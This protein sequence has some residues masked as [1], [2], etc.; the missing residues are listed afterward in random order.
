MKTNKEKMDAVGNVKLNYNYYVGEDFY[1][2]G[3]SEDI[4]LDLVQR[5]HASEYE[6]VIQNSRSWSVM[7]HL[8]YIRE[9]IVSWL[10]IDKKAKV[11]E[12]GAGCGA[13]TG[14]LAEMAGSVTCIELSKKRSLIN[15]NR[16]R[17]YDNIEIIVGNFEEIEKE[18]TEK[19]DYITLIGVLEYAESYIHAPDSYHELLCAV[20]RH[21]AP[22]GKLVTAIENR[23]GLKYFAGCK[24]DHTG[25]YYSGIEGYPDF[26]GVKT[27]SKERLRQIMQESGFRTKF[28]FPYPDY[29]LPHTIYSDEYLPKAGEL[30]TNLRNFDA[31]RVVTFDEGR[32]FDSLIEEGLFQHFSNSFLVIASYEDI[33]ETCSELPVFAK[34]ANERAAQYRVA[35]VITQKRDK[36][37]TV[38][39][40][41]LDTRTN[42]HIREI[43]S[44]YQTLCEIYSGTKLKP[45]ACRFL[46][47]LEPA[48]LI[49]GVSSKA[50]DGVEL[51]YLKGITLE[52][53][54]DLLE[55]QAKYEV[56][57]ALIKEYCAL[58][59]QVGGQGVFEMTQSFRDIF[60]DRK[61]EKTYAA[62]KTCNFDMIFSNIVYDETEKENGVWNVLDYEWMYRFPIPAQFII[63]R[64]LFY[65]FENRKEG[66][67][68]QYLARQGKDIYLECG[69]DQ[70]ERALFCDMEHCF[71]VYIISGIASL[72]VMQVMMPSA[73]VRLDKVLGIASYLRNLN[74]PKIYFSY[75]EG[76]A[77]ENQVCVLANV[78]DDSFVSMDISLAS[79]MVALRIDPTDY[80]CL[81]HVE[82]LELKMANG[83]TKEISRF[84]ING[85]KIDES[86]ILFDT[87]DA[88]IILGNLPRG[89][90]SLHAEYSVTMIFGVFYEAFRDM[91]LK[92]KESEKDKPTLL[93]RILFK[94]KIKEPGEQPAGFVYNRESEVKE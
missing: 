57:L 22:G 91:L 5:Y 49:A 34:Y 72:E 87:D 59:M 68:S 56:M 44:N 76:F 48:P 13:I 89:A 75:G 12:I 40:I 61:F 69:I 67:F 11:L 26:D 54:L 65:Y 39:K 42:P 4:L 94:C 86:T 46:Q 50:K 17:E 55:G 79:N 24:E 21:L 18:I 38:Y 78:S 93:D 53:Y 19:Y 9:N 52:K 36:K 33:W 37:R 3:S 35:T 83:E 64:S 71:Q 62:S 82:K 80:P 31:D 58:I 10:P 6:H 27:F 85:Y 20:G 88:Q 25:M 92:N 47:G 66:K 45:N 29:K 15:A 73:T 14:K 60:G 77:E 63:Y 41:A 51:S 7:Y 16:H 70:V 30:T 2:E 1:S 32:V 23:F 43:Y 74:M 90:K 84:L 28:Y 8:S 81:L